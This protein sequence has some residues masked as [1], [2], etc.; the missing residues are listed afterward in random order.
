[1]QYFIYTNTDTGLLETVLN[2]NTAQYTMSWHVPEHTTADVTIVY[3]HSDPIQNLWQD[4]TRQGISGAVTA[5]AA[6]DRLKQL[7]Q[8]FERAKQLPNCS[9]MWSNNFT[10]SAHVCRSLGL[11]RDPQKQQTQ[12]HHNITNTEELEPLLRTVLA[13]ELEQYART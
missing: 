11:S 5:P 9:I 3:A 1:M 2:H 7:L 6:R 12:L 13:D 10:S 8:E 4:L